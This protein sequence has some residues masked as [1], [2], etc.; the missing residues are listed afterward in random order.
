MNVYAFSNNTSSQST[1]SA[2]VVWKLRFPLTA[3]PWLS[4]AFC[5]LGLLQA[6]V[7]DKGSPVFIEKR[8]RPGFVLGL[9]QLLRGS[10]GEGTAGPW[11]RAGAARAQS[12]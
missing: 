4:P 1:D 6:R 8:T 9:S 5:F 12:A 2:A 7:D 10:G 11:G 3:K